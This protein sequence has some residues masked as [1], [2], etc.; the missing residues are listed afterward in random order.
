LLL[1]GR[2]ADLTIADGR[3]AAANASNGKDLAVS[4]KWAIDHTVGMVSTIF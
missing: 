2:R 4:R 3:E 1:A